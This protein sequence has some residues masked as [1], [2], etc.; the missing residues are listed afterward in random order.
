MK[1]V[2]IFE[3]DIHLAK[4]MQESI[5]KL[6][7]INCLHVFT[8]TRE[9]FEKPIEA[10]V[11]LLDIVLPD[12][13]GLDSIEK[14]LKIYPNSKIIMNSI[15]DN[16]ETIFKALQKGAVGYIDKESFQMNFNEV[17]SSVIDGGAYMTPNIARKVVN[18][19]NTKNVL[20]EKLTNREKDI[21][22]GLLDGLSYKLIGDKFG[23]GINTVR[24]NITKIYRKLNINSKG[25]LFQLIGYNHD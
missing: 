13:S 2:I 23:I 3:D 16:P 21:L 10:D 6:N 5:N 19:F 25:E 17:I 18:F 4:M 9:F 8:S 20:G 22:E 7:E 11:Y 1:Q 14:I 15:L 12:I 24:M